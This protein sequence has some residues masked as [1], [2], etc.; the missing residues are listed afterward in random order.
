MKALRTC[1]S[2]SGVMGNAS[3][4]SV[5]RFPP[6]DPSEGV[7][8]S[9]ATAPRLSHVSKP[10]TPSSSGTDDEWIA[11]DEVLL[12]LTGKQPLN[13][14]PPLSLLTKSFVTPANKSYVR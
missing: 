2:P 14:E 3:D 1:R 9:S 6:D 11:R 10:G 12:R 5:D 4:S 7:A 8:S 13:A